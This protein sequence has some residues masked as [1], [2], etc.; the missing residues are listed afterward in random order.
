MRSL[1]SAIENN[2]VKVRVLVEETNM[3][4]MENRV[5]LRILQDELVR[6]GLADHLE[7][8]LFDGRLHTKSVLIDN[9]MLI[10]GSQNF[11]YSSI[12][13]G[14]LNEFN[15]AIDSPEAL[16]DYQKM[17]EYYWQHARPSNILQPGGFVLDW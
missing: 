3:N 12:A 1:V 6:L 14:G 11:H 10:I 2:G 8:R 15:L 9:R 16:A 13:E 7:V 17:F 5:G 4:G